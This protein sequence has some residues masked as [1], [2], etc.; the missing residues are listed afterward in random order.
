MNQQ[1][2]SVEMNKDEQAIRDL[3]AAWMTASK[4]GDL[5]TVLSLMADDVIFMVPGREP[6]GKEAF[7]SNSSGMKDVKMDGTCD[8]RE[9]QVFDG[10]AYL[11]N[12]IQI[13]MTPPGGAP[14]KRSGFTLT[15]LQKQSDGRWLLARDANLV[16]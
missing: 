7:A 6:F 12:Y 13:S 3:V 11:R 2:P 16:T 8:I 9:L 15:I 4:S 5:E 10:W 1:G 14:I